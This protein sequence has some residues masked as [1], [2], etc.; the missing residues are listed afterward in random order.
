VEFL[1]PKTHECPSD[2]PDGHICIYEPYFTKCGLWFPL[3]EFLTSYCSR[4]NIAFSQLSVASIRNAV[5]LVILAS[6]ENIDVNLQLF[7]EVTTFSIGQKNPSIVCASSRRNFKIVYDARSKT[8]DWRKR[9][10]FVK[11]N[12]ASVKDIHLSCDNVWKM[13]PGR[14]TDRPDRLTKSIRSSLSILRGK[15]ALSWPRVLD[16]FRTCSYSCLRIGD[17]ILPS[18]ADQFDEDVVPLNGNVPQGLVDEMGQGVEA[19]DARAEPDASRRAR[20]AEVDAARAGKKVSRGAM[21]SAPPSAGGG[22]SRKRT[23]RRSPKGWAV[24]RRKICQA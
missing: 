21:G 18:Y 5:G 1:V 15:R 22:R 23:S 2:C 6:K 11:L 24:E 3:P 9:Y 4:R 12:E 8:T 10:F 16:H 17:C 14:F 13:D 20:S 19:E 7:E